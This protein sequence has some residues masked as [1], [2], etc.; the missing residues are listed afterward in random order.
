MGVLAQALVAQ[1]VEGAALVLGQT[2]LASPGGSVGSSSS[3]FP[4]GYADGLQHTGTITKNYVH[5]RHT[6]MFAAT[7]PI[8][9]VE[10]NTDEIEDVSKAATAGAAEVGKGQ[11]A[12]IENVIVL[13]KDAQGLRQK[14]QHVKEVM[15]MAMK[16]TLEESQKLMVDAATLVSRTDDAHRLCLKFNND[17]LKQQKAALKYLADEV[18][19]RV[20]QYSGGAFSFLEK[21]KGNIMRVSGKLSALSAEAGNVAAAFGVVGEE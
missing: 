8:P 4:L 10:V 18:P 15:D 16:R 11:Q 19:E 14:Q 2:A 20:F 12:V 9:D 7:M 21:V 13:K 5:L 6:T 17:L 1:G 3:F